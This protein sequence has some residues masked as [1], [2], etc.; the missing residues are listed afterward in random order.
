[1]TGKKHHVEENIW[2]ESL[3]GLELALEFKYEEND[4]ED[5]VSKD[6]PV[7]FI[8]VLIKS[9]VCLQEKIKM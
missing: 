6:M 9:L 2:Y 5:R 8:K 4:V 3:G 1:M 7:F